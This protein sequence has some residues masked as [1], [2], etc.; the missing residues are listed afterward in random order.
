MAS[1]W[2]SILLRHIGLYV[3]LRISANDVTSQPGEHLDSNQTLLRNS[4]ADELSEKK[5]AANWKY[6][7]SNCQIALHNHL[8]FQVLSDSIRQSIDWHQSQPR[9]LVRLVKSGPGLAFQ[10]FSLE[11]RIFTTHSYMWRPFVK[12]ENRKYSH[13]KRIS[14]CTIIIIL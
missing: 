14:A 13:V 1:N 6:S 3:Y 10:M 7:K 4:P 2:R 12:S 8:N 9:K 11:Q 5:L